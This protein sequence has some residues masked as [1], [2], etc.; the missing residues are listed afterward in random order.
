MSGTRQREVSGNKTFLIIHD[1]FVRGFQIVSA[2][3][4]Y[5][6]KMQVFKGKTI[7]RKMKLKEMFG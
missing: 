6:N 5:G 1:K 3:G 7:T 4:M 2:D